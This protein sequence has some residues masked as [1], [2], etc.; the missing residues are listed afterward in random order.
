MQFPSN[1]LY[2]SLFLIDMLQDP[3]ENIRSMRTSQKLCMEVDR[4][5]KG[6][7]RAGFDWLIASRPFCSR[8]VPPLCHLFQEA[9]PGSPHQTAFTNPTGILQCAAAARPLSSPNQCP[10]GKHSLFGPARSW[11]TAHCLYTELQRA[12]HLPG[13]SSNCKLTILT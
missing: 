11:M 5:T 6:K 2:L 9:F 13:D 1:N 4:G 8:L 7:S 10:P 12:H 3:F